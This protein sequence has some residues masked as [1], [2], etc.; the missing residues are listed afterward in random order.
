V[1]WASTRTHRTVYIQI[2]TQD[3]AARAEDAQGTPTQSHISRSILVYEDECT[4][5]RIYPWMDLSTREACARTGYDRPRPSH[6]H[7]RTSTLT[8]QPPTINSHTHTI[9]PEPHKGPFDR[10]MGPC[11]YRRDSPLAWLIEGS[12]QGYLAHKK[13]PPP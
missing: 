12:I 8:P 5:C 2:K 10:R 4:P 6:L 9:T 7:P 13:T 11:V 1:E 3:L